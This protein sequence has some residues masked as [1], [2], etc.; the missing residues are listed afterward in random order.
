MIKAKTALLAAE[1]DPGLPSVLKPRV[2]DRILRTARELFYQRGIRVV[3]V[4][5]ITSVISF[6]R[7]PRLQAV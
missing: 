3:S 7:C 1:D 2:R 4:D 6:S 5:A